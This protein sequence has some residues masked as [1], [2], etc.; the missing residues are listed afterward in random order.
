MN[1]Q[2]NNCLRVC[3]VK[4]KKNYQG[5]NASH[6]HELFFDGPLHISCLG[7]EV[8]A[9]MSGQ[10]NDCLRVCNVKMKKFY[11]GRNGAH[12][13]ACMGYV[14]LVSTDLNIFF[15]GHQV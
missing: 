14:A 15:A 9:H 12:F 6:F 13:C 7:W 11:R 8:D 4:M 10:S 3:N 5:G 1:G 2:S